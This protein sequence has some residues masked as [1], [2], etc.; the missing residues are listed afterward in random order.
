MNAVA[1]WYR[2]RIRP[3]V[4]NVQAMRRLLPLTG[5]LNI[6]AVHKAH[7]FGKLMTDEQIHEAGRL[8]GHPVEAETTVATLEKARNR[9]RP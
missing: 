9:K 7:Q 6:D 2:D 3:P 4:D 1:D 5:K 8:S